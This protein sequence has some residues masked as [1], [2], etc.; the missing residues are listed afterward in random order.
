MKKLLV[1][2]TTVFLMCSCG[3]FK[4]LSREEKFSL[5]YKAEILRKKDAREEINKIYEELDK[6]IAENDNDAVKEKEEY[7]KIT[8]YLDDAARRY[9][10]SVP[11]NGWLDSDSVRYPSLKEIEGKKGEPVNAQFR[12][13]VDGNDIYDYITNKLFTGTAVFRY[14]TG[15]IQEVA[16]VKNGKIVNTIQKNKFDRNGNLIEENFYDNNKK[17]KAS[18]KYTREGGIKEELYI[19]ERYSNG[20]VKKDYV[21]Y[22]WEK[23]GKVREYNTENRIIKE[24]EK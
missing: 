8:G 5:V 4:E 10:Y 24:T 12:L 17:L 20:K 18:K 22:N 16:E 14:G 19:L 11:G 2:L 9:K 1:V 7:E 3:S 6:H 23:T 13:Y 21:I 15:D